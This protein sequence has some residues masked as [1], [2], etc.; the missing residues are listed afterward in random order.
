MGPRWEREPRHRAETG[1]WHLPVS[2]SFCGRSDLGSGRRSCCPPLP[3]RKG[4]HFQFKARMI[5]GLQRS[6]FL[7]ECLN[8]RHGTREAPALPQTSAK[9]VTSST[10]AADTPALSKRV[11]QMDPH[12]IRGNWM[13]DHHSNGEGVV[14]EECLLLLPHMLVPSPEGQKGSPQ[15]LCSYGEKGEQGRYQEREGERDIEKQ[16]TPQKNVLVG[17]IISTQPYSH[18]S[19][20]GRD[21]FLWFD[22][23]Q[24]LHWTRSIFLLLSSA[25]SWLIQVDSQ[26]QSKPQDRK[27][28]LSPA[29]LPSKR[30][31]RRAALTTPQSFRCLCF[32]LPNSADRTC[33]LL[34]RGIR[35]TTIPN[36]T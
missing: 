7:K 17:K 34:L 14:Q 36:V 19:P 10:S 6:T 30:K 25:F 26:E 8:G 11:R 4:K 5:L 18:N 35:P 33:D 12:S 20:R 23:K 32:L 1:T 29:L 15:C 16:K 2:D 3:L 27:F 9:W 21:S 22:P 28:P 24:K 13:C 31:L